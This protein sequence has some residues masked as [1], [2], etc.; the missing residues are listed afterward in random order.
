MGFTIEEY[1]AT[2]RAYA[3]GISSVSYGDKTVSYRSLAEMERI[4]RKMEAELFPDQKPCRRRLAEIDRG[5]F[6]KR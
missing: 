6:P 4:L 3:N 2:R 1:Q 5:Y